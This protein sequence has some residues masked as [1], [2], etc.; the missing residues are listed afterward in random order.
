MWKELKEWAQS[1]GRSKGKQVARE[2]P[3]TSFPI[4]QVV[5]HKGK[6]RAVY[7]L[8]QSDIDMLFVLQV[9]LMT[10]MHWV[11]ELTHSP[12]PSPVPVPSSICKTCSETMMFPQPYGFPSP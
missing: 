11:E 3:S 8:L 10:N 9:S 12:S 4:I 6:A 1:Q 2:E 7:S 5:K